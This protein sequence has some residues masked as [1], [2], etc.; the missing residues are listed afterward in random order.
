MSRST[1][2][3]RRSGDVVC[4]LGRQQ[5]GSSF[6]EGVRFPDS[7]DEVVESL[8]NQEAWISLHHI[9]HQP[10]YREGLEA[11]ICDILRLTR[12]N[13]FAQIKKFDTILFI[14]SPRR[15]TPYHLD[16]ECSWLF[17]IRG[18][19]DI[20]LF[21][22]TDEE[23]LPAEELERYWARDN[24]AGRYKPQYEDRAMVFALRPGNGV[25]IPV[26]VPH[27]LE[28]KDNISI[29]LNINFHFHD[30]VM[31]NVWKANYYLRRAGLRPARPG[32]HPAADRIKSTAY[33]AVQH[34][35]HRLKGTDYVPEANL[36]QKRRIE[37]RFRE[38]L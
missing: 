36:E 16:R 25:H 28:N 31:G 22:R 7:I 9:E 29:S 6:T 37:R 20:H 13:L 15:R 12:R 18:D 32:R 33:T 4:T 5:A 14:T 24:S 10:E 11:A 21:P 23:I 17:Q 1:T 19:K 38:Q 27:W 35:K 30:S 3:L 8:E 34:L 26:N 2:S